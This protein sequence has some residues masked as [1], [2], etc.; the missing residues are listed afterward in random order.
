LQSG[1]FVDPV[2]C[3]PSSQHRA[4]LKCWSVQFCPTKGQMKFHR[5]TNLLHYF[6]C[7]LTSSMD[8]C[9]R[10]YC[11]SSYGIASS[12]MFLLCCLY[13]ALGVHAEQTCRRIWKSSKQPKWTG[14]FG[15]FVHFLSVVF[16]YSSCIDKWQYA[17]IAIGKIIIKV[18]KHWNRSKRLWKMV[19]ITRNPF[20]NQRFWLRPLLILVGERQ[21]LDHF[22]LGCSN[23][24]SSFTHEVTPAVT[25]KARINTLLFFAYI[26][27]IYSIFSYIDGYSRYLL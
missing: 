26:Q 25:N 7:K 1:W 21:V 15:I 11:F 23:C 20:Q 10:F 6:F 24:V 5:Y 13:A 18:S 14:M 27:S 12:M 16:F 4:P 17:E 19:V 2:K 22:Y 9:S 8:L 3:V